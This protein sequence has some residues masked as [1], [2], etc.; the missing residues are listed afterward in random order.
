MLAPFNINMGQS[1]TTDVNNISADEAF[2]AHL[3]ISA[4][5]AVPGGDTTILAATLL[6]TVTEQIIANITN[7]KVPRNIEI[8][9]NAA[10]IVGNVI[11]TG[12]NYN[13]EAITE[14]I[15]LNGTTVVEGNKA[16]KTITQIDLPIQTHVGTDTVSIG[17]GEKFG[18]PYKL[19]Y[20]TILSTYFN[21]VKE[22]TAP[23]VN[24]DAVVLE[25]NTIDLNS[26][27]NSKTIDIY[28]IV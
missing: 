9:G 25:N 28:L 1:L 27:L 23:I 26:T 6:T 12:S 7:P 3:Q 20:N 21:N 17:F 13:D 19:P 4:V 2:L 14:T 11:I 24:T 5:N 15:A 8:V 10:G 16:F 22:A 18:L